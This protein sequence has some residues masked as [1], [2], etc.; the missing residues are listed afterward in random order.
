V[1]KLFSST[2][3]FLIYL[4]NMLNLKKHASYLPPL[5]LPEDDLEEDD[6]EEEPLLLLEEEPDDLL[7]LLD[8]VVALLEL[9]LEEPLVADPLEEPLLVPRLYLL[10]EEPPLSPLE[11]LVAEV[12]TFFCPSLFFKGSTWPRPEVEPPVAVPSPFLL[13]PR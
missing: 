12:L 11:D 1:E 5:P 10:L 7:L 8:R 3:H 13:A 2:T 6:F 4:N 9:L